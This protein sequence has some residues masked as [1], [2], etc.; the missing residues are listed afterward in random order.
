[1]KHLNMNMN[2]SQ[3][4]DEGGNIEVKDREKGYVPDNGEDKNFCALRNDLTMIYWIFNIKV[5]DKV[6]SDSKP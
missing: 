2:I 1:M 5:K 3:T 4:A 6:R